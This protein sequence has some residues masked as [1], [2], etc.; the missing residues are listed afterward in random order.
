MSEPKLRIYNKKGEVIAWSKWNVLWRIDIDERLGSFVD[1]NIYNNEN[2]LIATLVGDDVID[3]KGEPI[4]NIQDLGSLKD[5]QLQYGL[6]IKGKNVGSCYNHKYL[7]SAAIAILGVELY[8][9]S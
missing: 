3:G 7:C 5:E 9:T 1:E 6:L 2:T 4:G 8:E